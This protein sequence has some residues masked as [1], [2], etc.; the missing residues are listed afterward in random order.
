SLNK[1]TAFTD[2]ERDL[3]GLRGLLPPRVFTQQEQIHR[4][5]ENFSRKTS[6]LEKYIFLTS[7]LDR[8]ER[9]FYRFVTEYIEM[10]MPIIYTPTVGEACR[11]YAHIFRRS[12]GMYVSIRHRGAIRDVLKNWPEKNIRVI[13]VTDGQ[14][15]LGLGDL[16]ANGMGIPVGK[17]SLYTACAG[18]P[19]DR[20]LPILLDVGTNN[21]VLL[22]DPLYMGTQHHRLTGAAYDEFLDE[23]VWA[24]QDVFPDCVLQFE[25]FG[26]YNAFALLHRYRDQICT[27]NDDIQGTAAVTL[28]GILGALGITNQKLEDQRILFLGAGEAALG[29]AD[30]AVHAMARHGIDTKTAREKCWFVDSRG[31]VVKGRDHLTEEKQRYAHDFPFAPTL[32]EAVSSLK[33][34]ALIGVSGV[35]QTFT[36]EVV[37]KMAEINERPIVFALSNPTSQAECTARQAYEWSD[38]RA[39]YASGSPFD[40]VT[41]DGCTMVPGQ[42]NNAY[43]FPG[44]GLGVLASRS[45][46][47]TDD[48]FLAAARSLA[49]QVDGG[50]LQLGRVYPALSHIQAVSLKIATEV[51]K[52]AAEAGLARVP[53]PEDLTSY[54]A[55]LRYDPTYPPYV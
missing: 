47:V 39:I 22:E 27:F 46:R 31:L 40:P 25:D 14:R 5:L 49:S 42:G 13:V 3:L 43:V 53:M 44:I 51:F 10:T 24:V 29:I 20:T 4:I 11:Q 33:P 8:N 23:F 34:T 19:P 37:G 41:M 1:G 6:N 7:L 50:S 30:L 36:Q 55:S 12:R 16:G 45:S 38:C 35:P 18:I 26:N 17:L 28:A 15:I 9:L 52:T 32:L 21:E 48:M 54:I 2:E